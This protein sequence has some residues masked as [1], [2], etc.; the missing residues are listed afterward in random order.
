MVGEGCAGPPKPSICSDHNRHSAASASR[1]AFVACSRACCACTFA[2]RTRSPKSRRLDF[3]PIGAFQ[4]PLHAAAIP[5]DLRLGTDRVRYGLVKTIAIRF[6]EC[7]IS[8]SITTNQ[9]AI[10]RLF[11]ALNNR[12][13]NL[14]S[15]PGVFPDYPVPIVR[16]A[17]D[18][19]ELVMARWG[20]PSSSRA[21]MDATKKRA[22]EL[23]AKGKPVDFKQ[24]LRMEPDSGTTNIRNVN[25]AHWRR[26]LGPENRCLVPFN[27]FSEYD[28]INGRK[29]PV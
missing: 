17:S 11:R 22:Q 25:S 14:A 19:R 5:L 3:P 18:G 28:T 24:L 27:S 4:R 16:N 29:V 8:Y 15:M 12:V 1:A 26:W 2:P 6:S 10:R 13:G 21:L 20:M 9:D 7:A 23:E